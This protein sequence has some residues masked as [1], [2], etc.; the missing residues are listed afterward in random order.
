MY[1]YIDESG[2]TGP[3]LFD[4]TQPILYYGVLASPF[5]VDLLGSERL[6]R[7]RERLGVARLHAAE[8]GSGGIARIS[9]DLASLQGELELSF[10]LICVNK[11]DFSIMYLFDQVFDQGITIPPSHGLDIGLLC[12]MYFSSSF[13][14]SSTKTWLSARGKLGEPPAVLHL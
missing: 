5:D 1:F 9:S 3:N 13:H 11:V 6:T 10:D 4:P 14:Y 8:L 2:H 12:D 7:V